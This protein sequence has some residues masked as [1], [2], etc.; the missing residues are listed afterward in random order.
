MCIS[1]FK[2]DYE[3]DADSGCIRQD[4]SS[5]NSP[6]RSAQSEAGNSLEVT[7]GRA[8]AITSSPKMKSKRT[9]GVDK[10]A[11]FLPE[12]ESLFERNKDE[13]TT[14]ADADV[15]DKYTVNQEEG[16]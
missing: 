13:M 4:T 16:R 11:G 10:N 7:D 5:E 6:L 15:Q 9:N 1:Y 3:M 12:S 14:D 8:C 2:E